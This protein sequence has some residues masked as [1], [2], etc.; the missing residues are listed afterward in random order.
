MFGSPTGSMLLF[1]LQRTGIDPASASAPFVAQPRR[2]RG[3]GD[4]FHRFHHPAG[5]AAV[6]TGWQG[7][8]RGIRS[9]RPQI[10]RLIERGES[11]RLAD[12]RQPLPF[13]GVVSQEL[14]MPNDRSNFTFFAVIAASLCAAVVLVALLM[15]GDVAGPRVAM[16]SVPPSQHSDRR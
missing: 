4:R 7:S 10:T 2:R 13:R 12:A 14:E 15:A 5:N 3:T 6:D 16:N 8:F 9:R 1:I 11:T